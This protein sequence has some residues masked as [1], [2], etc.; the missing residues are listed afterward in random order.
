MSRIKYPAVVAGWGEGSETAKGFAGVG[1]FVDAGKGLALFARV[2]SHFL[3]GE[4]NRD[5]LVADFAVPFTDG[6]WDAALNRDDSVALG[7]EVGDA[8]LDGAAL[9]NGVNVGMARDFLQSLEGYKTAY[10]DFS[11]LY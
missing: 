8:L 10:P 9:P 3:A 7:L 2:A 1:G 11:V 5:N 6:N 4:A